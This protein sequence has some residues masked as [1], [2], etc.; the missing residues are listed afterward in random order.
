[1][2]SS[3]SIPKSAVNATV[4]KQCKFWNGYFRIFA[5]SPSVVGYLVSS[6]YVNVFILN[7]MVTEITCVATVFM[8]SAKVNSVQSRVS[9]STITW[10]RLY[11]DMFVVSVMFGESPSVHHQSVFAIPNIIK[12]MLQQQMFHWYRSWICSVHKWF[13]S[14][15]IR[16]TCAGNHEVR[17]ENR[18]LFLHK[19]GVISW[20]NCNSA[21]GYAKQNLWF[22][23]S[24]KTL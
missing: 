11:S 24:H 21:I 6:D 10:Q 1:M 7:A 22:L 20:F 5:I 8:S 17:S 13:N 9:F 19:G 16:W 15:S 12:T 23:M 2:F 14:E 3:S 18:K 4:G